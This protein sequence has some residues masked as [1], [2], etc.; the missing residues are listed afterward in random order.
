ML[1]LLMSIFTSQ[2]ASLAMLFKEVAFELLSFYFANVLISF[3]GTDIHLQNASIAKIAVNPKKQQL[4][5]TIDAFGWYVLRYGFSLELL[6]LI[7]L[8]IH[9]ISLLTVVPLTVFQLQR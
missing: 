2:W 8:L 9:I 7:Y 5:Q 4:L 1:L 6:S 3:S